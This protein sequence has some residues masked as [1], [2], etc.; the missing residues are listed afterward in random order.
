[1]KN[2]KLLL[3]P[4]FLVIA[5]IVIYFGNTFLFLS[6]LLAVI[7]HELAHYLVAKSLGYKLNNICLMPYGA[8]L[9]LQ[10][11]I[12]KTRDEILISIAGP[13]MNLVLVL[14]FLALWWLFPVVYVYSEYFV[15]ANFI[16]AIFNLLPLVPL[17]GS[18]VILALFSIRGLRE[19]GYKVLS[20]INCI[21][22]VVLIALFVISA[23]YTIN[24]SLGVMAIFLIVGAFEKDETYKY[25]FLLA[26]EKYLQMSRKPLRVKTYAVCNNYD[27]Y[28]LVKL[29][30]PNFYTIIYIMDANHK[31]IRVLTEKN[32]RALIE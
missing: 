6:Y 28:K 2:E 10:S 7:L 21:V 26:H 4:I 11:S 18:R 19:K 8:Q 17:D 27:I 5:A 1:M 13:I 12:L 30:N 31:V 22:A 9:N 23:F 32:I 20:I 24:F 3:H 29:F 15:Y 25:S 14:L 16:T